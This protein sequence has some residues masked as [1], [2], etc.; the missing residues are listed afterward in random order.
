[1]EGLIRLGPTTPRLAEQPLHPGEA[2]VIS[3]I[4]DAMFTPKYPKGYTG[5]HRAA[6]V[7]V[8]ASAPA[9]ARGTT[10]TAAREVTA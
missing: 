4:F 1:L 5:R 2:P 8:K 9:V 6:L 7:F 3:R 10:A